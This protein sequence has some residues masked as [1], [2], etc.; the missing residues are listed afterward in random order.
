MKKE[1]DKLITF[2]DA[3]NIYMTHLEIQNTPKTTIKEYGY[4]HKSFIE[5]FKSKN[6]TYIQDLKYLDVEEYLIFLQKHKK[7]GA[8]TVNRKLAS[9]KSLYNFLHKD[10]E[11]INYNPA[12]RVRMKKV[13]KENVKKK[14]LTGAE[15]KKLLDTALQSEDKFKVRNFLI[16]SLFLVTGARVSEIASIDVEDVDFE[17]KYI[18]IV[19]AKTQSVR[20]LPITDRIV[21]I[22]NEYIEG[23]RSGLSEGNLKG[24]LLL[25]ERKKRISV[26][27][28][29][30]IV[31]KC[32]KLA[33][34]ESGD[35]AR[36]SSH[37]FRHTVA[38]ILH[39]NN[40][41]IKDIQTLL[42]HESME[43]TSVYIDVTFEDVR[44]A[45]KKNPLNDVI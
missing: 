11:C 19:S 44:K 39:K 22:L 45:V 32:F 40:V 6:K 13:G 8:K 43:S 41:P 14:D 9:L 10:V 21:D 42:G 27:A 7:N 15:A 18:K 17:N 25:S 28:I 5:F 4:D 23:E 29:Q 26:K 30:Y 3:S 24:S 35:K 1:S 36:Y 12:E 2:E 20:K 31:K 16:L 38:T 34:M 33:G 37:T